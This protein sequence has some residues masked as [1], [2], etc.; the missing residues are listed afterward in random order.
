MIW[1]SRMPGMKD[2]HSKFVN[3]FYSGFSR[4]PLFVKR[5]FIAF[6]SCLVVF[7]TLDL[8][9][10]VHTNIP[11]SRL[12]LSGEGKLLNASL[13]SD[14]QWRMK[15]GINE[16]NPLLIKTIIF[17]E[18]RW[19]RFHPGVN[20]IALARALWQNISSGQRVSGAST[21]SMQVIRMLEP[22]NRTVGNKLVEC[23]RA[24]QLELHH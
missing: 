22:R 2:F 20:P 3:R 10:P 21:I 1:Y 24:L 6:A 9:F 14:Q 17:K 7:L 12:I 13:S 19:F 4:L 11:Y 8:V 23:F 15:A 5:L 18:D 16:V